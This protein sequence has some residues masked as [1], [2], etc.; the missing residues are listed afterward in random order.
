MC[1]PNRAYNLLISPRAY[2]TLG[3]DGL[4]TCCGAVLG[5]TMLGTVGRR[6]AIGTMQTTPTTTGVF[7]LCSLRLRSRLEYSLHQSR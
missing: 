6:I 7:A 1:Q 2:G 5:T 4:T 3:Q